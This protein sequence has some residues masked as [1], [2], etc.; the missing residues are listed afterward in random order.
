MELEATCLYTNSSIFFK[1]STE[2]VRD[3]LNN[4]TVIVTKLSFFAKKGPSQGQIP[5]SR[6]NGEFFTVQKNL[7]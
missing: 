5:L 2:S 7:M 4:Y 6:S 3:S 1:F